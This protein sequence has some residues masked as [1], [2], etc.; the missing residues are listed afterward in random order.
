MS[1]DKV[2]L[3][4]GASSGIG[5]AVARELA[6]TGARLVLGARR[7][8]RLEALAAEIRNGGGQA[9]IQRLDVT[10]RANVAAFA[11]IRRGRPLAGLM[12]SSTMPASCRCP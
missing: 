4:T 8:D 9:I 3:I 2:I 1:L 10:N 12:S 11:E 5:A 6:T 7:T